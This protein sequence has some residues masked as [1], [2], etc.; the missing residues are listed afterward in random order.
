VVIAEEVAIVAAAASEEVS[1]VAVLAEVLEASAEA[2]ASVAEVPEGG[3][4]LSHT[5]PHCAT[6]SLM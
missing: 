3:F 6:A 5:A 4:S 1:E 2:E